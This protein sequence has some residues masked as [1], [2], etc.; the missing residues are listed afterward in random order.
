M[1]L[2]KCVALAATALVCLA[3]AAAAQPPVEAF[4]GLPFIS[5]P[6]LSPDGKHFAALQALDGKPAAVIYQVNAPAGTAPQVFASQ[7]WPIVAVHWVKNDRVVMFTR[8]AGDSPIARSWG[9]SQNFYRVLSLDVSGSGQWVQLFNNFNEQ[10]RN[11]S[12]AD[13]V[14]TDLNDQD[15]VFIPQWSSNDPGGLGSGMMNDRLRMD[16]YRVDVR[17]GKAELAELGPKQSATWIMDGNGTVVGRVDRTAGPLTDHVMLKRNGDWAD[18]F[19]T[20]A[21]ADRGAGVY[22]LAFDG[23]SLAFAQP[24]ADGYRTVYRLDLDDGKK[25]SVLFSDPHYDAGQALYD[26]WHQRVIGVTYAT[27]RF[28]YVYFD[29]AREA[30][31][32]GIEA[33]FPGKTAH[34]V[35]VTQDGSKAIVEVH[36]PTLPPTYYFLDRDTHNAT[37]IASSYPGLSETDLGDM[38]PYPYKARDGLDIHAYLT[39]P[40]G[41]PAKNLPVVV[42]AHGGPDAR[43]MIGFDWLVPFLANRGYAVLQPNFRG[44]FGYGHAF[45]EAGLNQ[46]GLKVQDDITDGVKKLISDGIADPKRVCVLGSNSGGFDALAG[47]TFTP[48]LYA[49]AVSIAGIS[50]LGRLMA[51]ERLVH[52]KNSDTLSYW[53]SR[54]GDDESQWDAV[55]PALHADKVRAPV[56]LMH[57]RYDTDVPYAQSEGEHDALEHAGGRVEFVTFENGDHFF[58]LAETRIQMLTNLERFLRAN[59]GQ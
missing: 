39:L 44:S 50:D 5:Q 52:G 19:D 2:T 45:T 58:A 11:S 29:P 3:A 34:A 21:S 46:W 4:G 49:C 31:Q 16:L 36:A 28:E 25:G 13:I 15:V 18:V 6:Q 12:T 56:L 48:D 17:T 47:V 53:M 35:S 22:G 24:N 14:D 42:V 54:I 7:E 37:K 41:K 51:R 38:K 26:D 40:P 43:Y 30:L 27:D 20:D 23:K 9:G 8:P 10:D 59:I 57:A 1:T 33:V 55:S 32:R